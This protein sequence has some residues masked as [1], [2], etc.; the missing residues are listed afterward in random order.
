[1]SDAFPARRQFKRIRLKTRCWCVGTHATLYVHI[2]DIS[3]GGAFIKTSSPFHPGE[4]IK[5]R[6]EFPGAK[7]EHEAMAQVVWMR[8]DREPPGMG[9][10]FIEIPEPTRALLQELAEK[11][12]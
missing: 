2:F 4:Q 5:V 11:N 10:R 9:L 7:A 6:W 8:Q 12:A 1:M 3:P